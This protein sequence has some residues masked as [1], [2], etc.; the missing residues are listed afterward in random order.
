[1][2]FESRAISRYLV[3]KYGNGSSLVPS[4]SDFKAYG[5]FEQAASIEY[6][7]FDPAMVGLASERVYA[8]WV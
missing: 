8:K 4:M 7:S 5:L 3:A 2:L 6:S 1:M